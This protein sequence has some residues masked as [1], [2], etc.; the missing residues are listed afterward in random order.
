MGLITFKKPDKYTLL[1]Y[2]FSRVH[3]SQICV[4]EHVELLFPEKSRGSGEALTWMDTEWLVV[5]R[6][7]WTYLKHFEKIY[8]FQR[9]HQA[10]LSSRRNVYYIGF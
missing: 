3:V 1:S 7:T 8:Q 4:A 9:K 2:H 6:Q 5:G 10:F